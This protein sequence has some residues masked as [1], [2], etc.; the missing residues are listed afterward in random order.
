MGVVRR[1]WS[2]VNG[3]HAGCVRGLPII[4]DL[5]TTSSWLFGDEKRH[6]LK[7]ALCIVLI[8][9]TKTTDM[10]SKI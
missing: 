3:T 10:V 7:I 6:D 4:F 5:L 2:V 1:G 8:T 9:A